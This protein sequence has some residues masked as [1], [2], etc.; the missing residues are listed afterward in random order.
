M[1]H[2]IEKYG[3][4]FISIIG[5]SIMKIQI[6]TQNSIKSSENIKV[7]TFA[8]LES[9]DTYDVNIF[10]LSGS[11]WFN[12]GNST[13]SV[14]LSN[15]IKHIKSLINTASNKNNIIVLPQNTYFRYNYTSEYKNG[16]RSYF[17]DNSEYLKSCFEIIK[18]IISGNFVS[19]NYELE[20]EKNITQINNTAYNS[21]FYIILNGEG[22][23]NVLTKSNKSNKTTSIRTSEEMI[24]T[25]L[26]ILEDGLLENYLNHIGLISNETK[27]PAWIDEIEILDDSKLKKRKRE[28]ENEVFE[29]SKEIEKINLSLLKNNEYKSILYETGAN[30]NSRVNCILS[31]IFDVS[32]EK[33]NDI[34]EEDFLLK[35]EDIT[36]V[37][38]VKGVMH[39]V[40]GKNVSDAFNHVQVYL[41]DIE[42][43]GI[44]EKVKGILIVANQR[45]INPKERILINERQINIAKRN[46]LLIVKTEDLLKLYEKHI[47]KEI[48]VKEI[49]EMFANNVGLLSL[50]K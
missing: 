18:K 49:T 20:Y 30:L 25:T 26:N 3:I 31:E 11:F 4:I 19:L 13:N 45:E 5:G 35:L 50:K 2:K 36:F 14:D 8:N 9:L 15:D 34:Y 48:S 12:K 40:N 23:D 42:D 17:Y 29:I 22:T 32:T 6:I 7:N 41:D 27:T 21:D 10:D 38:E 33:F 46:D 44:E 16:S 24:I 47:N 28:R 37:I 1:K 39:N 43:K